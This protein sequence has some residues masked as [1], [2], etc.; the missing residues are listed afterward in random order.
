MS[1]YLAKVQFE[2]GEV[3]KNGDSIHKKAEFLVAAESVIEVEKKVAEYMDGTTGGYETFQISKTK[4][5]A[6]IYDKNKYEE[7]LL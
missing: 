1:Y 2:S 6:V 3:N 7:Q 5:E 4:I